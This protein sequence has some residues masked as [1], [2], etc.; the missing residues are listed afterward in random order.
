MHGRGIPNTNEI[1]SEVLHQLPLKFNNNDVDKNTE[2]FT[3]LV[4]STCNANTT[5]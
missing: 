2:Q 4:A 5:Y 3:L 1:C